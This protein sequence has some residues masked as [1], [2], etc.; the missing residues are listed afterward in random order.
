MGHSRSHCREKDKKFQS[1]EYQNLLLK[2]LQTPESITK[3]DMKILASHPVIRKLL[4]SIKENSSYQG[5]SM[6]IPIDSIFNPELYENKNVPVIFESESS[7][8]QEDMYVDQTKQSEEQYEVLS[9]ESTTNNSDSE[10]PAT[11]K[12][13]FYTKKQRQ[14]KILKYKKKLAEQRENVKPKRQPRKYNRRQ[15]RLNGRF[16]CLNQESQTDYKQKFIQ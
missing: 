9:E 2:L 11:Q 16:A 13:G 14:E 10:E 8:A 15:P 5:K 1:I 7:S 12:V 3:Q 4:K 6:Y